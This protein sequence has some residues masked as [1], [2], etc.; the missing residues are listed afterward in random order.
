MRKK[1][2]DIEVYWMFETVAQSV[3]QVATG[4]SRVIALIPKEAAITEK[5]W[6]QLKCNSTQKRS[7]GG[8]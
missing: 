7:Q 6:T 5:V 3:L 8:C 2:N 1:L 4:T